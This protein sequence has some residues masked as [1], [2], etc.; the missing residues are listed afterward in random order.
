[1]RVADFSFELPESLIAH[2]PQAERSG[3]RLLSLDGPT[4]DLTHGVFTD[5]LD[6]LNPGDLLVFNNTR[7]IPARLFGRKVSGGKLEVLVERVLDDHRVLAHVRASKAPKPGTEL[8]LGDDESVKATMAARHDALFELHF[9][10]SRDVLSILNDIGHMPLPPYIDRPDED[11]D[12]ELYQ[13]VYSQRPGAVAAPTAGLHFD[14]PML[15]ALREKGIEMAFV[16]LHV[17]AGTFQPVRVDTIE[18]HIMHAE[19][20]E[21]PQDVVDAVL[22][23]KARG[24][25]VIAV[26]TTSVRSLESAAQASQNAPI[27]PFF[28]DTKIFIYPGYHY[29]IIDALV[30]N[31]HL[32]ESTLIMLVSAFAGY[33]NTMSA[34]RQAVSEQYRFFSYG[35][36]MF[37]THNPMAEQEKVG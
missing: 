20:A 12:R 8:L 28:G 7:V 29:R 14:E 36:A 17:G 3:C 2:Y 6:K 1:M 33:Q 18:D 31:F 9:D 5:L 13:T 35:D 23:C 27:E 19:Y 21:V 32:P 25:R 30:T 22:A 4:G 10:D 24:N 15:A 37:I 11:A 34:Y 16:T 26:G